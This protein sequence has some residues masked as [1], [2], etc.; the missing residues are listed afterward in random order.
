M[1]VRLSLTLGICLLFVGLMIYPSEATCTDC[2]TEY[3]A[4]INNCG[5]LY[6]LQCVYNCETNYGECAV[7][8]ESPARMPVFDRSLSQC[9]GS[10]FEYCDTLPSFSERFAC[11]SEFR[12]YC[13]ATYPRPGFY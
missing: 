11:K 8:S 5:A 12:D 4:C 6:G 2:G 10:S 9:L 7:S 1:R 3:D 13:F